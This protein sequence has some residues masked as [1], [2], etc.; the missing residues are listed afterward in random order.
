LFLYNL[1]REKVLTAANF[2]S[3]RHNTDFARTVVLE[4]GS[5]KMTEATVIKDTFALEAVPTAEAV[6]IDANSRAAV[7]LKGAERE[8][9]EANARAAQILAAA[10]PPAKPAKP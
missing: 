6:I 7:A 10:S 3:F 5:V 9:A 2:K 4:S 1:V 8:L